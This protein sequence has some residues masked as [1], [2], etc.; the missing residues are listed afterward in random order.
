MLQKVFLVLISFLPFIP[1]DDNLIDWSADRKLTWADFKGTPNPSSPN[2]ALTNSSINVEFGFNGKQ[3]T[4]SIKCRFNKSLSWGRIKNDYILN[5]EQG[6]FDIAEIHARM[7]HKA[8]LDYS[9]N[10]K[11][12]NDD[13][14]KIYN[15]VVD[16]HVKF[17]KSYDAETNHSIDTALQVV[18]DK[19]IDSLLK[20]LRPFADY[21]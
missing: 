8:F 17:Q 16:A 21:K 5:H 13:V 10:A 2:A 15:K 6:H 7:L 20:V 1:T 12:V 18:W 11:T 14:T 4:H 19:K 3:M 9:F